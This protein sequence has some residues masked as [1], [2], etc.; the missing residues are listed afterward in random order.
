[1]TEKSSVWIT[2]LRPEAVNRQLLVLI[3]HISAA[4]SELYR[5]ERGIWLL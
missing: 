2:D 4:Y 1:M 5:L 3:D